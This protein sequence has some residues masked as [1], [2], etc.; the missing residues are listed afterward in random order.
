MKLSYVW[1]NRVLVTM[2]AACPWA[3]G[4]Q[5]LLWDV[6]DSS[7]SGPP[8]PSASKVVL[9]VFEGS[10]LLPAVQ[11]SQ[12]QFSIEQFLGDGSVRPSSLTGEDNGAGIPWGNQAGLKLLVPTT[13]D[14]TA[15]SQ[16]LIKSFTPDGKDGLP[17]EITGFSWGENSFHVEFNER[18]GDGSVHNFDIFG[19]VA[20]DF[21][22]RTFAAVPGS[23]ILDFT[24]E[25]VGPNQSLEDPLVTLSLT[26]EV[27]E[28][29]TALMLLGASAML[30]RRRRAG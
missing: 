22:F 24:L 29:A 28:P 3:W 1:F 30:V 2:L 23:V 15:S 7:A 20:Q 9:G 19:Q 13:I 27:P 11:R 5:P 12:L 4:A 14:V 18:M 8:Y 16:L 17:T 6:L 10:D 26:G 21:H 25:R